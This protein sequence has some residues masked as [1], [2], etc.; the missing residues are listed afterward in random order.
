MLV[1]VCGIVP[2]LPGLTIYRGVFAI[3][4]DADIQGDSP[5]SSEPRPSAS[6]SPPASRWA[7]TSADR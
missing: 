3:V 5:P 6:P 2:L 7:S 4:V 1:A